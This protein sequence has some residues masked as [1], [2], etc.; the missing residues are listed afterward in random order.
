MET[1]TKFNR[2]KQICD[3]VAVIA[4]AMRK[5]TSGLMEVWLFITKPAHVIY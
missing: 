1:M 3:D 5:S 2:L 4:A